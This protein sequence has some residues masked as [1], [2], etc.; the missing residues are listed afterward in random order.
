MTRGQYTIPFIRD[1][2]IFQ[3]G[4]PGPD[5]SLEAWKGQIL[6]G[7]LHDLDFEQRALSV[8]FLSEPSLRL[9]R[10]S[11]FKMLRIEPMPEDVAAMP[12]AGSTA[13]KSFTVEF[14]DGKTFAGAALGWR[15]QAE[16]WWIFLPLSQLGDPASVFVPGAGIRQIEFRDESGLKLAGPGFGP[17]GFADH[18]LQPNR[19]VQVD[20]VPTLL[21]NA[22]KAT[23]E[24]LRFALEAQLNFKPIPIGEALLGLGKISQ[25]QLSQALRQQSRS[26]GLPLGQVLIELGLVTTDDL[27]LALVTKM[28]Y[29][30]VDLRKFP[31]DVIA[32]RRVPA[33]LAVKLKILPLM[34]WKS[35]LIVAM[36]DPLQFRVLEEIEFSSQ[37]KVRAVVTTSADLAAQISKAYRGIGMSEGGETPERPAAPRPEAVAASEDD[38]WMLAAE[39]AGGD[40]K[41]QADERPIEQSD[42]TLVRLINSMITEAYH[43]R[44]SDIHIEPYPGSERVAIRFRIDGELRPYLELPP[45]Y[46][47]ALIARIKIMCNL[48]ISERRKP[49]DGKIPFAKFGGLPLEL[50]VATIPT[51]HGLEDVVMRLLTAFKL[52][53]LEKL[54]LSAD[55]LRRLQ[56]VLE[57]SYGMFLCVGPTGS[58]KSTT[59]HSSLQRLNRPNRKIWTAEDPIEITQHGLRQIQVNP[60]IGWNFAAALRAMLRADPDVIMVGEIRDPETAEIAIEAS[61]TG[62]LVLSTLHTNSAAETI[63]RLSDLGLD[64]FSFADSLQGVLAQRLVRRLCPACTV[65]GPMTTQRLHEVMSHYQRHLPPDHALRDDVALQADWLGRHG[66]DG[67]L[68]QYHATGCEQCG[69]T[70]Y[71]GRMALHELLV[72]NA[73]IRRLVQQRGHSAEI[74]EVAIAEGMRTLRQDGIEKVLAGMTSLAEVRASTSD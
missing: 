42:N 55:N 66:V 68:Q 46:R 14:K 56:S 16:G 53:P 27:Q 39:L 70:G 67:Q 49:Q 54:D 47:N 9:V 73:E 5:C 4:Q 40:A 38:A 37:R 43:Q 32:L 12:R 65:S 19:P 33:A 28:G 3:L 6:S 26:P 69:N 51:A 15:S 7:K 60:K 23:R 48:D 71:L 11:H 72:P 64:T 50:R 21:V 18:A 61:L 58:G 17:A 1:D 31:I 30:F 45:S 59:L 62:H 63:V 52:L 74:Q 22:L 35:T 24:D 13:F 36:A 44:A 29:P 34:E 8:Q 2:R 10:L 57:R 20:T 41:A 25:E